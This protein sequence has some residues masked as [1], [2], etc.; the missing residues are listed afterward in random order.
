MRYSWSLNYIILWGACSSNSPTEKVSRT[1]WRGN[2]TNHIVHYKRADEIRIFS[3]E[4]VEYKVW[5][6]FASLF[7]A[8]QNPLPSYVLVTCMYVCIKMYLLH[9]CFNSYYLNNK[10]SFLFLHYTL[11][12]PY[13]HRVSLQILM[14]TFPW[15][16]ILFGLYLRLLT[17]R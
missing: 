17:C 5:F 16:P 12:K 1:N 8:Q 14:K 4:L 10:K 9:T 15:M 11:Q 7:G 3:L 2:H 13:K 6:W